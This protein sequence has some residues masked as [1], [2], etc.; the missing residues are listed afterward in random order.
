[1]DYKELAENCVRLV[2]GKDNISTMAHCATR[3]RL[4]LADQSKAQIPEIEKLDRVLGVKEVGA[5]TQ[6]IIGPN[7]PKVYKEVEKIVGDRKPVS[8]QNS[9]E[10][11][12]GRVAKL[13]DTITGIFGPVINAITAGGMVKAF[14][15]ILGLL[16][17]SSTSQE[18]YILNF[19][20]DSVF[21]FLPILLT[22]LFMSYVEKFAERFSPN[23]VK[24]V[25]RPLLTWAS[26]PRW[27]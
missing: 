12:T 21:Y 14:L 23:A 25:L 11:K 20:A 27:L 5:Q 2:G 10:E 15:L 3:L 16:G 24:A 26:Q 1:M 19:I 8:G 4:Q 7:V 22:V 17:L 13:L 18:Y 9:E 6:I